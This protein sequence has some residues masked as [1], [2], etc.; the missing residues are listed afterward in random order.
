M[1]Y[2]RAA[3]VLMSAR[4]GLDPL[5]QNYSH[6]MV[7]GGLL[8]MSS[9]TRF[10]SSTSLAI[11][12][13]DLFQHLVREPAPYR[14]HGVFTCYGSEHDGVPVGP[15]VT[16]DDADRSDVSQQHHLEPP[17]VPIQPSG[18]QLCSRDC[19]SLPQYREPL[20]GDLADDSDSQSGPGQRMPPDDS[21]RQAKLGAD[22]PHLILEER[23]AAAQSIGTADPQGVRR[24][25]DDS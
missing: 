6:S 5:L 12:V 13:L 11:R 9:T 23:S 21:R 14:G 3:A 24:R 25:C 1:G 22:R 20:V 4:R 18:G 7:A 19:I 10:T 2:M 15:T 16:L 17:D 8:V